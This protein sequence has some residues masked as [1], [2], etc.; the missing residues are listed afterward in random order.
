MLYFKLLLLIP[1]L[2]FAGGFCGFKN[3]TLDF[4]LQPVCNSAIFPPLWESAVFHAL[5]IVETSSVVYSI[6]RRILKQE[7][8]QKHLL[9]PIPPSHLTGLH[10][11]KGKCHLSSTPLSSQPH[12]HLPHT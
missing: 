1:A 5:I 9:H 7:H 4:A 8:A 10:T 12:H 11:G 3:P 2:I 6:S